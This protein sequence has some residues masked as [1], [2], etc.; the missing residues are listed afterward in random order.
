MIDASCSISQAYVVD[1]S[2][3]TSTTEQFWFLLL[4][5]EEYSRL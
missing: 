1:V 4:C 3:T 2:H 5:N